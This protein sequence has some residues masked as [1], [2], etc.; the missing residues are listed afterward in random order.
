M[1]FNTPAGHYEYLVRTF[2]LTNTPAVFQALLNN[3]L[4]DMLNWF[5]F[6]YLIDILIF[7][8]SRRRIM[9]STFGQWCNDF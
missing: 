2:G 7:S 4:G 1:A 8:K 9:C 6:V 5:V 3:M